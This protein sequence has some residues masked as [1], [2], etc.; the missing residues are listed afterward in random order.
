MSLSNKERK[1]LKALAHHLNPVIRIG[2]KGITEPLI[3]ETG[4]AL[5][6]HELIKV[7]IAGEDRDIRKAAVIELA[8]KTASE[9]I[10]Q[11]GK[12]CV[13][14]RKKEHE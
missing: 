10:H 4:L 5:D 14:Y 7:H 9:V 12:T 2:Q 8:E 6:T 11:I 1:E 13:L 3:L